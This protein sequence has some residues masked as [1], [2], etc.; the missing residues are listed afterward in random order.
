MFVNYSWDFK[1]AKIASL[2]LKM[3]NIHGRDGMTVG[4]YMP[5]YVSTQ[6]VRCEHSLAN[7]Y[8]IRQIPIVVSCQVLKN[9]LAIW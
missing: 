1:L 3:P 7:F 6:N 4:T 2:T 5:V 9:N 8:A